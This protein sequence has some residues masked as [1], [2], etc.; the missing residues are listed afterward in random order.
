[1]KTVDAVLQALR[2]L[3]VGPRAPWSTDSRSLRPGEV[4]V[5]WPGAARD[6]R[7]FAMQALA[8][9]AAA[10][11]V[12]AEGAQH[13]G[14][15]DR[16]ILAVDGLK[17]LA[18]PL[19]AAWY[20]HPSRQVKLL[21]VTGTNGKTSCAL[22]TA[23][24]L[25]AAGRRCGV[26]G[27]LGAGWPDALRSTGFTTPDPV[28]LQAL[29]AILREQGAEWC[30]I[31]ASSIG[32]EEH[33]LAGCELHAAAFTNLTQDHLDYHGDMASYARAKQAL[34][35]WPGL[36]HA[37]LDIDDPFGASTLL[38]DCRS[39]GLAVQT[40][41]LSAPADWRAENLEQNLAGQ[42]FTLVHRHAR[43]P[44][45]LP[46][47][48]AFNLRNLL[49]V[50]ALLQTTGMDAAEIADALR[51]VRAVPGRMQML[52][53]H[54]APLAV[55]DYAHTPDALDKAL[56]ALRP[57]TAARQGRLWCVF[58]AGGDRDARKRP[59]MAQAAQRHADRVVLT[60]DN[61]R[62]E[63]PEAILQDLLAGVTHEVATPFSTVEDRALA[64]AQTLAHAAVDDVVLI[65]GK[66]HENTQEIAGHKQA[67]SDA[68]HARMA[69]AARGAGLCTLGEARDWIG[70]G[71]QLIGEAGVAPV[72][73]ETDSRRLTPGA[74]FV[75][76]RGERF[77]AH[78]FLPQARAAG[79]SA[80]LAERGI[81]AAGLPGIEVADSLRAFGLLARGWRR[82]QTL[83][84]IAVTGSNGKT[85][86]TQMLASILAAWHGDDRRLA[87]RGNFNNDVGVPL[88]LL[89]LR[90]QHQAAV[91]ELGMNHPGE[92]AWLARLAEP[93][94]AVVNNAQREHQ[95]FM[96]S[97]EA[98]ARENG[99]VLAALP[100]DGVAVFPADDA[101]A[102]IWAALSAGRPSLRFVLREGETSA[103]E[104]EVSGQAFYREGQLRLQLHTPA[105][106]AEVGLALLG[107][108]N[109]RNALAA[110]AAALAAGAP[111]EAICRGLES[112]SPVAGR[113]VPHRLKRADGRALLLIDDS[114]NANPD[115]VR[116]AIDV[117]AELP[118]RSLLLLGDMGEVGDQGPAFH[119]EVGAYA[120]QRGMAAL[121]TCGEMT[122]H[123][124][125]AA[126]AAGL[127][128]ARHEPDVTGFAL[129]SP[130][131]DGFDTVLVKGSRFMRM[132]RAVQDI[133]ALATNGN[134]ARD[135]EVPHAA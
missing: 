27:T 44:L 60:S 45:D 85:T 81:A 135:Q 82:Q 52:G 112:F 114:Y 3:R 133:A 12:E 84:L 22:W 34:F 79:A 94:V 91:V 127:R 65:A 61:P 63:A 78:E 51:T 26:I 21:A 132:E 102:A 33:R 71:A 56:Q 23:Q 93:T 29:L 129:Q 48:G 124:Q 64:I 90:P 77:D 5:A 115:S 4:F 31:E 123:T 14:F 62:S 35:A 76:L 134:D 69:L 70:P 97:V 105:G 67:F 2:D 15:S 75:A 13:F 10:V 47:L 98:V 101:Q 130:D 24:A 83:P 116:A 120:A 37:V 53:G 111:L 49:V 11:L 6:P 109:A 38:E 126:Q 110:T 92:I 100:Q 121:W 106:H 57:V 103:P 125:A 88:T 128:E 59:L 89:R 30:A 39:R 16:R 73:V 18:G 96:Q 19:A 8:A 28:R 32:L 43:H 95:E 50:A 54:G 131:L 46:V 9:G 42:R 25:N 99:A 17:A 7:Q 41:A 55:I 107:R 80:L 108:H 119:A 122:A 117:L 118:G 104:A 66:G 87:T 1:M 36:R 68:F 40:S 74:L 113:L 86:V 20:D 58:G 72:A